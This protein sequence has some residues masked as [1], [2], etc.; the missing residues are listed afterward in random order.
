MER[1]FFSQLLLDQQKDEY[2]CSFLEAVPR[3]VIHHLLQPVVQLLLTLVVFVVVVD[4]DDD[5][6]DEMLL[7]LSSSS[8][9][10]KIIFNIASLST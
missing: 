9:F 7:L 10:S 3:L 6:D 5:D 8:S 4:D 1:H 2:L